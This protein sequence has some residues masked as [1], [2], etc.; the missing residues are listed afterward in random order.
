MEVGIDQAYSIPDQF[1]GGNVGGMSVYRMGWI[2]DKQWKHQRSG[3]RHVIDDDDDESMMTDG[4][5]L[6][7]SPC[8]MKTYN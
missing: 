3:E 4:K 2:S 5:G 1:P 8:K 7:I 6:L